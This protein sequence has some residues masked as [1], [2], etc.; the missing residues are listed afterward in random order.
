MCKGTE[1]SRNQWEE[2]SVLTA[3]LVK[4]IMTVQA[5]S[6]DIPDIAGL[7]YACTQTGQ[8]YSGIC[9]TPRPAADAG[10][11]AG[12]E[13]NMPATV[14]TLRADKSKVPYDKNIFEEL[15]LVSYDDS[16]KLPL[17]N[18][19]LQKAMTLNENLGS[20]GYT[21]KPN[22]IIAIAQSPS[23]DTLFDKVNSFIGKVEAEPMYK[24]FPQE[25]M[26]MDEAKFRFHQL[27]HYFSTYGLRMLTGEEVVRGWLPG[28]GVPGPERT[29]EQ[30]KMLPDK[31]LDLI[32]E[33]EKYFKPAAQI[34]N[35]ASRMTGPESAIVSEALGHLTREQTESLEIPFKQN[36]MGLF[37]SVMKDYPS[38]EAKDILRGICKHTGDV[39][40]CTDYALV[41]ENFKLKTSE[42]RMITRLLES[43]SAADFR[44]NIFLSAKKGERS[45]LVL[46]AISYKNYSKSAVH[47]EQV[48]ALRNGDLRSWESVARDLV[49]AKDPRAV[50]FMAQ[51][52]GILVRNVAWLERQN[53]DPVEIAAALANAGDQLST[54]TLAKTIEIFS[55]KLRDLEEDKATGPIIDTAAYGDRIDKITNYVNVISILKTALEA[56]LASKETPV[57]DRKVFMDVDDNMLA[58][59]G[60]C[61]RT[62]EAGGYASG[63]PFVIPDNVDC[64]RLFTYWND[65]HCVDVD[66]HSYA[67]T[68]EGKTEHIGWNGDFRKTDGFQAVFSGDITHSNA[69]EY[70]D[71]QLPKRGEFRPDH[72]RFIDLNINLYSGR[73]SF[74][75]VETCFGGIMAVGKI[76]EH[77]EL[78]SPK[79]CIDAR[80]LNVYDTSDINLGTI[81]VLN[82]TVIMEYSG[83]LEQYKARCGKL[84]E[85]EKLF[86]EQPVSLKDYVEAVLKA[87]NVTLVDSKEEADV[88]LTTEKSTDEKAISLIDSNFFLDCKETKPQKGLHTREDIKKALDET[89][90]DMAQRHEVAGAVKTRKVISAEKGMDA[91]GKGDPSKW[92]SVAL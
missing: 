86:G 29:E 40:K 4:H 21:L 91:K 88:I 54:Q 18:E 25:V 45:D 36:M 80:D 42:K 64:I 19:G 73:P 7:P 87:Q 30:E 17:T 13:K 48:I 16:T 39:L 82:R 68:G 43:Y 63:V 47:M 51:R 34:L 37:H 28:E 60:F 23:I 92:E 83:G 67:I 14:E 49:E 76:G 24:G 10:G 65:H 27:L 32:G 26:E 1:D 70:I 9:R 35:K 90:E 56:N 61:Y 15:R 85:Y 22:D 79:N 74:N 31:V 77:V 12:K 41:Q 84:A 52:P 3:G 11:I 57:M 81:D 75:K 6:A 8:K 62:S 66:L 89:R 72:P 44:N 71:V 78:Y 2:K 33:S 53:Y 5:D 20:L 38:S 50:E 58:H 46:K 59:A 55:K 69:A